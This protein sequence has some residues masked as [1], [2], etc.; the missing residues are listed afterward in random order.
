MNEFDRQLV[1]EACYPF[2][3]TSQWV[4]RVGGVVYATVIV[5]LLWYLQVPQSMMVAV[6]VAWLVFLL[7]YEVVSRY[8]RKVCIKILLHG[9]WREGVVTFKR[10]TP[11]GPMHWITVAVA[12][13]GRHFKREAVVSCKTYFR[14]RVGQSVL[15]LRERTPD[16][17][18]V[19]LKDASDAKAEIDR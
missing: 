17:R 16:G 14:Y 9:E 3:R 11:K 2:T 1:D 6:G 18:W 7:A 13:N 15:V 4:A 8:L 5:T 19:L 10:T 12:Y